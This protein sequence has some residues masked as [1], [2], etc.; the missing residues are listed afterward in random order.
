M[1]RGRV[2][3]RL[4]R[5][6]VGCCI[7]TTTTRYVLSTLRINT[8][9]CQATNEMLVFQNVLFTVCTFNELFFIALYLLSF[10]S[11]ILSPSLLSPQ[12]PPVSAQP[13]NPIHPATAL[14][15]SPGSAWAMELARANK[16][17]STVPWAVAIVSSPIMLFKQRLNVVQ[18]IKAS[19]WLAEGD[20]HQRRTQGLPKKIN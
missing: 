9:F 2:T 1:G 4:I 15:A 6:G 8:F 10:S 7:Y 5:V 11:P 19:K 18:L 12:G 13:G 16:M 17:D 3:K 20:I 14:L